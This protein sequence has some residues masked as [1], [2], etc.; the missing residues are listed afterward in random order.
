M[1]EEDTTVSSSPPPNAST[2][3]TEKRGSAASRAAD[4]LRLAPNLKSCPTATWRAPSRPISTSSMKASAPSAA[5]A[6]S[7]GATTMPAS[8]S[9]STS[10]AFSA[11]GVRRNTGFPEKNS[12]GWG[13]KVSAMTGPGP[14][15]AAP[16]TA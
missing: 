5:R 16:S 6:P 11:G 10:R 12:R 14:C 8:P 2:T 9:A 15:S 3:V 13:S 7:N 1:R 4:P